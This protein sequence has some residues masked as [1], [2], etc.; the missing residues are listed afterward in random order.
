LVANA[1]I[2]GFEL[3]RWKEFLQVWDGFEAEKKE[4]MV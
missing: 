2:N 4:A 3:N 1:V